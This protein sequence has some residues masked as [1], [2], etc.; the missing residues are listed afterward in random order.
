MNG[1]PPIKRP[2]GILYRPR[3]LIAVPLGDEDETTGVVV[4]GT[5]DVSVAR[6]WAEHELTALSKEFHRA[7]VKYRVESE[8]ERVWLAQ[9]LSHFEDRTPYYVYRKD[10]ERGRAGVE[11]DVQEYDATEPD[12]SPPAKTNESR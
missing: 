7:E 1:F 11:F 8:G 3:K 5:H 10:P 9:H 6:G 2:N 4:F 12:A